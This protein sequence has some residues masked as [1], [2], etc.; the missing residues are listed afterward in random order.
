ME[1]KVPRR[2]HAVVKW[3]PEV[4]ANRDWKDTLGRHGGPNRVMD[5]NDVREWTAITKDHAPKL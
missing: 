3:D 5:F 4:A 2:I 1:N